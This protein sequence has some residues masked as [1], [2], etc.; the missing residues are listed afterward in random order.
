MEQRILCP[1]CMGEITA[2]AA[3][4]PHC[5]RNFQGRNPLGTLPVGTLLNGRYTVGEMLSVDGEGALSRGVA[6]KGRV[7]VTITEYMR[8]TLAAER[9]NDLSPNPKP[10]S[11]V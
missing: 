11:E 1:Y 5:K 9:G 3:S 10:G 6:N 7:R 8:R 2:G 4:C